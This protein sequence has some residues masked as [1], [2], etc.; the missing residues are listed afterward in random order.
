MFDGLVEQGTLPGHSSVCS[1]SVGGE[2]EVDGGE[3]SS[4]SPWSVGK[5]QALTKTKSDTFSPNVILLKE[6]HHKGQSKH[7]LA[8]QN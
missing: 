1:T 4:K 2:T 5:Q 3:T 8:F 7:Q 6:N